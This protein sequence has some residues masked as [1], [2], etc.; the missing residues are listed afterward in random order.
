ML[1]I[2]LLRSVVSST[3][4]LAQASTRSFKSFTDTTLMIGKEYLY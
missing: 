3:R 1:F 4:K 2:F